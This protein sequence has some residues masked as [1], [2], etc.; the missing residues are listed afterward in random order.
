[1]Y[2]L[3]AE[4]LSRAEIRGDQLVVNVDVGDDQPPVTVPL[5][6]LDG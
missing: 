2:P 5:P 1:M 6:N 4:M 3:V